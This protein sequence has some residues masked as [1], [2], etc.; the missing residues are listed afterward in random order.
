MGGGHTLRAELMG[1]IE[2]D[3]VFEEEVAKAEQRRIMKKIKKK[4]RK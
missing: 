1:D 3:E 4:R 2:G